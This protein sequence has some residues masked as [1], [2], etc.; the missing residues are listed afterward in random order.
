[1]TNLSHSWTFG[2]PRWP[3][4][5]EIDILE[6]VHKQSLNLMTL[7]TSG[8]CSVSKKPNQ[9]GDQQSADCA[10]EQPGC[11]VRDREGTDSYGDSFNR[12]GGGVFATL[13]GSNGI[14][15]WFFPRSKIPKDILSGGE[16]QPKGWGT[17]NADFE[18]SCEFD[19]HFRDQKIVSFYHPFQA[20][21]LLSASYRSGRNFKFVGVLTSVGADPGYHILR[22]LGRQ[23]LRLG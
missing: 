12:N 10:P 18:G 4:N 9:T 11:S 23:S 14:K 7:H 6:G 1:M 3:E 16:P 5:G 19:K 8:N 2:P 15:I 21:T 17:P 20:T 13:W 22:R